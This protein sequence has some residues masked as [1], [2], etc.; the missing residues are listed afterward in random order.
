MIPLPSEVKE[1]F[2]KDNIRKNFRVKFLNGTY[3]D[4]TNND[5]ESES[6]K[7]TESIESS[8]NLSNE[9]LVEK[10][11]L[12]FT[13]HGS[14]ILLNEII[15]AQIE[16]DLTPLQ[17]EGF[18]YIIL[19]EG[20]SDLPPG[21]Y[22]T[23]E[24]VFDPSEYTYYNCIPVSRYD[25]I[26]YPVYT[27]SY[28]IFKIQSAKKGNS[29]TIRQV[30]A[31]TYNPVLESNSNIGLS[32]FEKSKC[33]V[34]IYSN[35]PYKIF[36]DEF[37]SSNL[38]TILFKEHYSKVSEYYISEGFQYFTNVNTSP[39][40]NG[41]IK[42]GNE[43]I[44]V[45]YG[46]KVPVTSSL[47]L[48]IGK[49]SIDRCIINRSRALEMQPY[50]SLIAQ[51][52]EDSQLLSGLFEVN[53]TIDNNA[54]P[55]VINMI[56]DDLLDLS[57]P[58]DYAHI[59]EFISQYLQ[60]FIKWE[61]GSYYIEPTYYYGNDNNIH[62]MGHYSVL[63]PYGNGF[64]TDYK[65][66]TYHSVDFYIKIPK[67]FNISLYQND[68]VYKTYVINLG[69]YFEFE[70]YH[71][72]LG[73]RLNNGTTS[74]PRS[75]YND[76]TTY[77]HC[78]LLF[79]TEKKDDYQYQEIPLNITKIALDYCNLYG[80]FFDIDRITSA[81]STVKFYHDDLLPAEDL[82]PSDDLYP[83]SD[84]MQVHPSL[85]KSSWFDDV[86]TFQFNKIKCKALTGY[87]A[88][89]PATSVEGSV[90]YDSFEKDVEYDNLQEIKELIYDLENNFF[91]I[92]SLSFS[93]GS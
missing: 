65:D 54:I 6:V 50:L 75:Y 64:Y 88:P 70:H 82:Y 18:D 39:E 38:N 28:G 45:Y 91:L 76:G 17:A 69:K 56:L 92:V 5:L 93:K 29:P 57:I 15:Q 37:L 77:Y 21:E 34:C 80:K 59:R 55:N 63:Y 4:L 32:D 66:G 1:L 36:W 86:K 53:Q 23:N 46:R 71:Y 31:Y 67:T 89:Q 81:I 11:S 60:I 72:Y 7:F 73:T 13:Y 22:M 68:T 35:Y 78:D 90:I 62:P 33:N 14:N 19:E 47:S 49:S 61:Y 74:Y 9:N 27:V 85:V 42:I 79:R 16:I 48:Q 51:H 30:T 25:D 87:T 40:V 8:F 41:T 20:E 10:K 3:P 58:D 84:S 52:D 43:S 2:Q 24:I 26:D 83:K 12:E 44:S